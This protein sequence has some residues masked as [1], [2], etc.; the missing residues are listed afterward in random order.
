MTLCKI[1]NE[2]VNDGIAI[3][4][5]VSF[6]FAF[7]T[8]FFFTYV[9]NVEKKEFGKQM[10]IIVDN[11]MKDLQDDIH[12]IID[13]KPDKISDEDAY[14]LVNGIIDI[15]KKETTISSKKDIEDIVKQNKQTKT[16]AYK[17]VTQVFIIVAIITIILLLLGFCLS[18][19]Y[20][21]KE[22]LISVFFVAITEFTFLTFITSKYISAD[23]NKVR[24]DLGESVQ[25]WIQK[26]HKQS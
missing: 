22:A 21:I 18:I 24:R 14:I 20:N 8:I 16:I 5:Q 10:D 1:K 23:P 17:N 6:I 9:S 4:I 19:M 26:N 2:L 3:A 25:K 12:T 15:A 13:K 7:L 11:I